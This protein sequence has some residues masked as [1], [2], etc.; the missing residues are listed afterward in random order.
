MKK[1]LLL[2]FLLCSQYSFSQKIK[3]SGIVSDK[4]GAL[5]GVSINIKGTNI[6]TLTD[7]DGEYEIQTNIGDFLVFT[8]LGYETKEII[9]V[10]NKVI[11]MTLIE[12]LELL[13]E[14]MIVCD[15]NPPY[16]RFNISSGIKNTNK[17]FRLDINDPFDTNRTYFPNIKFGYQFEENN[18]KFYGELNFTGLIGIHY[19]YGELNFVYENIFIDNLD[20]KFRS[21]IAEAKYELYFQNFVPF[22]IYAGLG[23]SKLNT[24]EN[25]FGYEL[26]LG[27]F[28]IISRKLFLHSDVYAKVIQWG[29]NSQLK[30]GSNFT[31]RN[32]QLL[33][34]LNTVSNYREHNLT[35]GYKF[36][37]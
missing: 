11:N 6:S 24:N 5:P 31:Y 17:G 27:K 33:Y 25:R 4:D 19:T 37:L 18:K 12:S 8:Y 35:L 21:L 9:I 10:S 3:V 23:Y 20:F 2:L 34:E 30:F 16:A 1:L 14:M 29:N 26:G 32:F 15:L 13:K 36:Y 22:S 7:F 28:L